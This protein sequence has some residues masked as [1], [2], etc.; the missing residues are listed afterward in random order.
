VQPVRALIF[1]LGG[2]AAAH[3]RA[4]LQLEKTGHGRLAGTCDPVPGAHIHA[5][6]DWRFAER[7]VGVWTDYRDLLAAK[8]GEADIAIIPTPI[9]LHAEMH[10]ASVEAGLAVYL[11]K[12]PSLDPD[13]LESMIRVDA[14]ARRRT[15]VGFNFIENAWRRELKTRI[16]AGEFGRVESVSFTGLWPRAES[17]FQRNNWA[18]R[19]LSPDGRLLL[20]SCVGNAMAHYVHNVLFWAG[21]GQ[22]LS[23]AMPASVRAAL[24]RAHAIEGF[25]TAFIEATTSQGVQLRLGLSHACLQQ[26]EER[27][28]I[29]C[30]HAEIEV[31]QW[32]EH[33]IRWKDGREERHAHSY[34]DTVEPNQRAY[35]KHVADGEGRPFT[36][37]EDSRPFVTL[38]GLAYVA[39]GGIQT[40]GPELAVRQV[41][42]KGQVFR[43]I[44]DIAALCR[45]FSASGAWPR[46]LQPAAGGSQAI[47]ADLPRL[48]SV[49]REIA[50]ARASEA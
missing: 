41:D 16:L 13:E 36:T 14:G 38:N 29:R 1:G 10:R 44:R 39:S 2:F 45:E 11:E 49:V 9:P 32:V 28:V 23:W 26:S 18:G 50:A 40:V 8:A 25:D 21:T 6:A 27:E 12:P 46:A 4:I 33:V 24:F 22:V 20:D 34:H 15:F 30:E 19:L 42:G 35:F 48:H 37:L 3:H 31:N 47:L 7:G 17:Y 5:F 43:C